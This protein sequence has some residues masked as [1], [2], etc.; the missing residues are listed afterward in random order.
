MSVQLINDKVIITRPSGV[1]SAEIYLHGATVTSFKLNG[2]EKLFVSTKAI[3]DG[4]K[5]IRGGIPLVFPQFGTVAGSALPQ[6]GFARVSKWTFLGTES[7]TSSETT[8]SF[9]LSPDQVSPSLYSLW[10]HP[11]QLK[12]TVTLKNDSLKTLLTITNKDV[13]S[14]EFTTLLHTYFAVD[15][16][17][18]IS[19]TGLTGTNFADKVAGGVHTES[20]SNV[21]IAGEVDRVYEN[22]TSK[23]CV[24]LNKDE[25][26]VDLKFEKFDDVVVW[27]PWI[28]K[29][30]AMADFNDE[31]YLNMVCVEVGSVAKP[32]QLGPG[33]SW[34]GYQVIC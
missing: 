6:H 4:S 11:F 18:D 28:E 7:D 26:V 14:F 2:K 5:A 31:G 17:A 15:N 33:E 29:A 10:P 1:S 8:V 19:I 30:K 20:R 23:Q 21:T 25:K 24:I 34:T 9:G 27:N 22:V 3:L 13:K 12:Y 32:V 16:I